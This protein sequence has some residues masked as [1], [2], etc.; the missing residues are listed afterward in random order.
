[1]D[2][3]PFP[4]LYPEMVFQGNSNQAPGLL[5]ARDCCKIPISLIERQKVDEAGTDVTFS[6]TGNALTIHRMTTNKSAMIACAGALSVCG[7]VLGLL[8]RYGV[9]EIMVLGKTDVRAILWPSSIMITVGWCS[10]LAGIMTTISSMAINCLLYI[11]I[12][13][14][15]RRCFQWIWVPSDRLD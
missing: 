4:D 5:N 7:V 14:L 11:G 2:E 6:T 3:R 15:L 8:W 9:W 1:M 13:L 12:A 10:T